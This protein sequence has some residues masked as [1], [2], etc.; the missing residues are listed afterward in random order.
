MTFLDFQF[1]QI[2]FPVKL[3]ANNAHKASPGKKTYNVKK[4]DD[5]KALIHVNYGVG[6]VN[7]NNTIIALW[8]FGVFSIYQ[9]IMISTRKLIR[10]AKKWQRKAAIR[11]K[12]ISFPGNNQTND[13]GTSTCSSS[14]T[15]AEKGHVVVYTADQKR[16]SFF[17]E[18]LQ[19]AEEEFGLPSDGPITLPCEAIF[20]DYLISLTKRQATKD[21][22]K[23]LLASISSYRCSLSC[24]V[25][26]LDNSQHTLVHCF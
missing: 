20:M 26:Q 4:Y 3:L 24:T 17:R 23:E 21:I 11:R 13:A 6:F 18:L 2:S 12:R 7:I 22:E 10:M 15:V 9:E 1:G 5:Q 14:S 25:D 16:Y 8:F 19:M